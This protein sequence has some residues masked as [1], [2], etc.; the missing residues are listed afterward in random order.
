MRISPAPLEMWGGVECTV[1]RVGARYFDQVRRSGHH[2]RFD[3]LD[4]FSSLHLRAM[5]YPVLW[6]RVAP[7]GL[8]S[9]DWTWTDARLE[10]L[11]ERGLRPIAGLI[12]HGS[13]PAFTNLLDAHFP[14]LFSEYAAAVATRY[15]WLDR[16]TPINEPLTT[17]RF[18][19][20][21][22]HW[23]PHARDDGAFVRA[24]LNQIVATV[25]ALYEIR[26]I[27]SSARLVQTEDAGRTYSTPALGHQAD[28]EN[29]RRWLTFDLLTGRVTREHPLRPWL[30]DVSGQRDT[31]EW[32]LDHPCPPAVLG[33]NY[34]LTSD[35]YLDEG[36]ELYPQRTHGG[37][38]RERYADVEAVRACAMGIAG[39]HRVLQDAW[40]RYRLPVALTEV[41]AGCTREDQLRWLAEAWTGALSARDQGVD[42]R[43]VTSWALLGAFDWQSLVV[44]DDGVYESG[45][46][47]VRSNPPRETSLGRLVRRLATGGTPGE[48]AGQ[49][50]WWRR[51]ERLTHR[52]PDAH[53]VAS[54]NRTST[55]RVVITGAGGTLG[56]ALAESCRVRSLEYIALPKS[57]ADITTRSGLNAIARLQPWAVI[58]A[59]GYVRVDE[60]EQHPEECFSLNTMAAAELASLCQTLC[61]RFI[62][63]STDLV[64]DGQRSSAYVESDA[65]AP[66][67]VY[68][69]SKLEAERR[70]LA[71]NA[72]ALVIRTS[73]FF[74]PV[75]RY[76]FLTQ[77][78]E[79]LACRRA[80]A[81]ADDLVVSP[82]YVPELADVTLDLL[83]DG[84]QGIWHAA[85]QGQVSW[86]AFALAGAHAAGFDGSLLER[87]TSDRLGYRAARPVHSA[88][89]SERALL[90]ASLERAIERYVREASWID[91]VQ[92]E[93]RA[94]A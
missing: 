7:E 3:D 46:F 19:A 77:A 69:S 51:P 48:I 85:N 34:Y 17:S 31:L 44:R 70:V 56:R 16:Y 61:A 82:T 13:G 74:G 30:E 55:K 21:Y 58:N 45:A 90:F 42:V 52:R 8:A 59:A 75:D 12:H 2:D 20:L 5:R 23:Y 26:K 88:L 9:A 22:G 11:R 4:L 86:Y 62:T 35:R 80:F 72:G 14:R 49:C 50:G 71:C 57:E 15:P 73:A 84:E 64:F 25:L 29:H 39:H 81:A 65:P 47:D 63:F 94:S 91:R 41:H 18:S 76:N 24:L 38:G 92:R 37:N 79:A 53:N 68:G 6:E 83:L 66:L 28:F 10:G 32:L 54:T 67:N 27:N 43:A 33:L 60:A 93:R 87:V 1:N 36:V 78:L 40:E 89:T